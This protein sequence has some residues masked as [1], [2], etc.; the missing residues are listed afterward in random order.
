MLT[1]KHFLAL[2]EDD[3]SPA[4]PKVKEKL[5]HLEHIEDLIINNGAAGAQRALQFM[6]RLVGAA[7]GQKADKELLAN[8]KI[9]GAPS[10]VAGP[11][12]SGEKG[13]GEF[14]VGTKSALSPSGKR[15][16]R[17]NASQIDEENS[18]GLA[19]KLKYALRYLPELGLNAIYQGDFLFTQGDV[20]RADVTGT[21]QDY[22][23]FKPNVITY[24]V[25][26]DSEAGKSVAQAKMGIVFHTVYEGDTFANM[27]AT[28]NPNLSG[29]KQTS[30]VWWK[31]N[32]IEV[33][34]T[35]PHSEQEAGVVKQHLDRAEQVLKQI[36]PD[37]FAAMQADSKMGELIKM[38]INSKVRQGQLVNNVDEHVDELSAFVKARYEKEAQKLK[39]P[40]GQQRV[41]GQR[42]AYMKSIQA[43]RSELVKLFTFFNHLTAAKV[44]ALGKLGELEGMG[45]FY[46]EGGKYRRTSGEGLVL[47][48]AK[49]HEVVKLVDRLDFSRINF[50]QPKEWSK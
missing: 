20:Q 8:I 11:I 27:H 41:A 29:L 22:Y 5:K 49:S 12:P 23:I 17:R 16:T 34:K 3:T 50:A 35:M 46:Q 15:Y 38:H 13:A 4:D 10:I 14:F 26:V 37:F 42:D 33:G 44:A 9:D 7:T 28:Y 45:A 18:P 24:A 30:N 48:D 32:R 19:E 31:S 21:K 40:A 2:Y 47:A 36:S 6:N 25:P 39:T 1:F 43:A